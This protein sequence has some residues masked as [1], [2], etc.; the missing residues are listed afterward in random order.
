MNQNQT[1]YRISTPPPVTYDLFLTEGF[2]LHCTGKVPNRFQ[3]WAMRM[4]F[5][6]VVT[7]RKDT[8]A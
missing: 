4:V 5:G 2:V 1:T 3:R 6:F 8:T 7:P